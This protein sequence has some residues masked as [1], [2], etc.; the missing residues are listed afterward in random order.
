M[1]STKVFL[2]CIYKQR[3]YY[4]DMI[5]IYIHG[6]K[7]ENAKTKSIA[8]SRQRTRLSADNQGKESGFSFKKIMY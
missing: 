5:D 1:L 2:K 4:N 3:N 7:N 8:Y 6:G